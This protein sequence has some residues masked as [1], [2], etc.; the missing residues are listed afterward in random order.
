MHNTIGPFTVSFAVGLTTARHQEFA[1]RH[2]VFV[3][4]RGFEQPSTE[5]PG[6]ERDA[7]DPFSCAL[8]L[9]DTA[10]QMPVAAQRFVLPDLLPPPLVANVERCYQAMDGQPAVDFDAPA[11]TRWAEASR[12]TVAESYRWGGRHAGMPA[13]V[14]IHYASIALASAFGRSVLYSL[15]E[16]RT[17]RLI[18]RLRFPMV[19]VGAAVEF[20]GQ[21]APFMMRVEDMLDSVRS[22]H[23]AE[24]ARLSSAALLVAATAQERVR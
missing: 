22:E 4:E 14:A 19:R 9:T 10:T 13:M 2:R 1:L 8:L 24:L 7:F 15:S 11:R 17:E 23:R 12:T 16:L 6:E 18:R 3:E 5:H 20:H 21:R